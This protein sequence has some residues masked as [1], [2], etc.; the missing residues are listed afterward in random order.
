MYCPQG[1]TRSFWT[2]ILK[3][4]GRRVLESVVDSNSTFAYRKQD[5]Q[6]PPEKNPT[7]DLTTTHHKYKLLYCKFNIHSACWN[8]QMIHSWQR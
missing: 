2:L 8:A 5:T 3:A 1:M 7:V 6:G 4:C